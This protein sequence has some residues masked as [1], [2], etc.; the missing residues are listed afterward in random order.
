MG[1]RPRR[2]LGFWKNGNIYDKLQ[3]EH[4]RQP[5]NADNMYIYISLGLHSLGVQGI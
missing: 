1:L 2:P 4:E 3:N 5:Y